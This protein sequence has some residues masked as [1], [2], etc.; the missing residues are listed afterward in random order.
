M[1]ICTSILNSNN[2]FLNI[3]SQFKC[4]R[5]STHNLS[6]NSNHLS[7]NSLYSNNNHYKNKHNKYN[8]NN[9][10][11]NSNNNL[12]YYYK[13][14]CNSNSLYNCS[15][16][17]LLNFLHQPLHSC[18]VSTT[19]QTML[20]LIAVITITPTIST[21]SNNNNNKPKVINSILR[22]TSNN[23]LTSMVIEKKA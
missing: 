13:S 6:F 12:L 11:F 17:T 8:N 9:N 23:R 2:I 22:L 18:R 19:F 5:A 1:K 20:L 15:N 3:N 10:Q 4:N 21:I 7:S 14:Q 16:R